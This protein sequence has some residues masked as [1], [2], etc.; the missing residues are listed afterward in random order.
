M[1]LGEGISE[2]LQRQALRTLFRMGKF[3]VCDGLDDY[4]DDYNVFQPLQDV[5]SAQQHL[6][7]M[8]EQL[9]QSQADDH[10]DPP[11]AP[12]TASTQLTPAATTNRSN[13]AEI[14]TADEPKES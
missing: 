3:N 1:F 6:R 10:A 11:A 2:T 9:K 5:L 7:D 4:A 8:S 12:A 13:E 14:A